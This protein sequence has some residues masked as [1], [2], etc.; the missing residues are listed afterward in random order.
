MNSNTG[1]A[2]KQAPQIEIAAIRK[3]IRSAG[4]SSRFI[5][6]ALV[7]AG[8]VGGGAWS[9]HQVIGWQYLTWSDSGW[10]ACAALTLLGTTALSGLA[11]AALAVP[12]AAAYREARRIL[13]SRRLR[14][15]TPSERGDIL[16]PL[17][18]ES[19]FDSNTIAREL[20]R[21]LGVSTEVA[22]A[23]APVGRG[24]EVTPDEPLA[25]P[26]ETLPDRR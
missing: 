4:K 15:L 23:S 21:Q 26:G 8:A 19:A 5:R 2:S 3:R 6:W 16:V 24:D 25:L 20:I 1:P 13:F 11:A 10:A 17:R 7:A 12:V 22:P 14:S 18:E 9:A